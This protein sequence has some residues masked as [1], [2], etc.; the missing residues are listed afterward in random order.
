MSIQKHLFFSPSFELLEELE[1]LG[2]FM[3]G[4]EKL[5]M[6]PLLSSPEFKRKQKADKIKDFIEKQVKERKN[7]PFY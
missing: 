4:M 7:L 5:G 6:K 2:T 3:E 1:K